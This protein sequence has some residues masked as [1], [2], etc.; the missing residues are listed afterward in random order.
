[1]TIYLAIK[2]QAETSAQLAVAAAQGKMDPDGL[3]KAKV[4]NGSKEVPSVLLSPIA[5]TKDNISDTVIKD[6][7][8]TTDEICTGPYKKACKEA[9]IQ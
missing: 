5:V 3:A 1:M 9:G 8:L 2:Q 6:G 4:D 7:F